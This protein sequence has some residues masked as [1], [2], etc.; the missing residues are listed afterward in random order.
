MNDFEVQLVAAGMSLR[1]A[2]SKV[3]LFEECAAALAALHH[4]RGPMSEPLAFFVPGRIE[5]LGKHTDY[6]GGRSILCAVERGFV[7][8][9]TPR[10]DA[11]IC[12]VAVQRGEERAI[13]LDA[14]DQPEAGD[15]ATYLSTVA[16]RVAR[17]FPTAR[18]GMDVVFASDLPAAS[19]MSSSSALV[20]AI[21]L[22]LREVNHLEDDPV[23]QRA[24]TSMESLAEYLGALENGRPF[25]A[26]EGG[27]GVGTLGGSQDQTAI[28][29][30]KAGMLSRYSF[31]P[32]RAEGEFP[33]P[34]DHRFVLAYSGVAAEKTASARL[35]Y[36]EASLAVSEIVDIWNGA[37]TRADRC[38]GDAVTSAPD[39]PASIR[40]L[41]EQ[42][43][44]PDFSRQRLLD[45]F[46]QFLAEAYDIIPKAAEAFAHSD[47]RAIGEQVAR[48]QDGVERLLGN[49]VPETV[50]LVRMALALGADAASAFGAGFGGSVWAFIATDRADAFAAEWRA[51][52]AGSFPEQATRAEFMVTRPGPGAMR[53]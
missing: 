2:Q 1:E 45:R 37:T 29:C 20:I 48:S 44:S 14:R 8:L 41:L 50:G 12:A 10:D 16:R 31:C 53:L 15:W 52:Y 18:R 28:L 40:A 5:V 38:L 46:D 27:L 11:T 47:L 7:V 6:A 21:F 24:I 36:N 32:V 51:M 30:C 13:S 35:R 25:G 9:A 4:D 39:A 22:A 42:R 33:S 34:A 49:Q 23:Y 3:A 17:D 43:D 26:L 19:G